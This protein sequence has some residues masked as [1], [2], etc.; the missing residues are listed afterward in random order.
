MRKSFLKI[1]LKTIL[2]IS[3]NYLSNKMSSEV[4]LNL[5]EKGKRNSARKAIDENID[6][7]RFL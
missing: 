2:K 6:H 5:V 3:K 7:V 1:E 4:S